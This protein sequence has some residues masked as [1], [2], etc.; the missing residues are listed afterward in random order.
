M[1]GKINA[2]AFPQMQADAKTAPDQ[3][4]VCGNQNGTVSVLH[5]GYRQ[6]EV[7]ASEPKNPVTVDS[8]PPKA[9]PSKSEAEANRKLKLLKQIV[10]DAKDERRKQNATAAEELTKKARDGFEKLI[11]DYPGTK[12]AAEAQ[13]FLDEVK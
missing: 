7:A 8:K 4:L 6:E 1:P 3:Y 11:A 10:E 9:D 13:E 12:A 5:L 2:A